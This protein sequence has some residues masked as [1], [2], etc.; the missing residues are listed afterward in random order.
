MS[1]NPANAPERL[2]EGPA[3]AY[4]TLILAHGAG[5]AMR[6]DFLDHFARTLAAAGLRVVRFEFPFMAEVRRTG[7]RRPPDREPVLRAAWEEAIDRVLAEGGEPGR[8]LIGGKSLGGRIASL[9]ADERGVA[10]L[11]CLGYP[12]HPAGRPD[13]L[14]IEHLRELRTPT[15]ICQGT[16]DTFGSAEEVALYPLSAPIRL[17]WIE[18]GEHSFIPRK[19]S[20]RTWQKNLDQASEAILAFVRGLGT[21]VPEPDA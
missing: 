13:S 4:W 7:K 15:L 14:R 18:D 8:L 16:R 11:V 5:Q 12:F 17:A 9:I 1:D 6:S 20:G 19:G 10:G 2:V 3:D 21:A